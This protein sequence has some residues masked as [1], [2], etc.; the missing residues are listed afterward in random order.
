MCVTVCDRKVGSI[1]SNLL[2]C[3]SDESPQNK[4]DA[5]AEQTD[6]FTY[7]PRV[8]RFRSRFTHSYISCSLSAPR[9]GACP[10]RNLFSHE[11]ETPS[12]FANSSWVFVCEA[13][14]SRTSSR[15][16]ITSIKAI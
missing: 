6:A 16:W 12:S 7:Y 4:S 9:F 11:A 2:R 5:A 15:I 3:S 14:Y 10:F 8:A 1:F 13:R